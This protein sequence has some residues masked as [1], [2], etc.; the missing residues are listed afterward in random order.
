MI[1][2]WTSGTTSPST[3]IVIR[4]NFLDSGTGL[5]SQSIFMRNEMVDTGAAGDAMF[6][7]NILIEDNVIHNAHVHGITVGETHGLTIRNN[8]ILQ[9]ADS[10]NT[11]LVDVPTINVAAAS[12]GVTVTNNILPRLPSIGSAGALVTNNL[13]VQSDFP[14]GANYVGDLFVDAL[15][16]VNATLADL[17]AIP[18]GILQQLGVGSSLTD[19]STQPAAPIGFIVDDAGSGLSLLTHSLDASNLYGPNGRIDLQGAS[20]VWNFGD[21]TTAS[22]VAV[23]HAFAH[24]GSYDVT[25]TIT[26]AGGTVVLLD[27][28]ISVQT[29]VALQANF[30]NGAQDL[31]DITNPVTVVSKRHIRT[32]R[33][34]PGDPPQRGARD[35]PG[36]LGV[37]QQF[38]VHGAVRFQEGCWTGRCRRPRDQFRWQRRDLHRSD[39]I[40]AAITTDHGSEWLTVSNIGIN[41]ADW[42]KVALT[43]SANAGAAILYVDGARSARWTASPASRWLVRP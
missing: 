21:G 16:G 17:Q 4:G 43:F 20:V 31:S 24:A 12:T 1:Q 29:P 33:I 6:Y 11:G 5:P 9:N 28:T 38:R 23:D 14:D 22:G 36:Q 39:G 32:G 8:T 7:R 2:F 25:A 18:G 37:A 30:D 42:H 19:F 40:T 15:A 41:D 3:N 27:K 26:L 10:G 34:R 13:I 35:L